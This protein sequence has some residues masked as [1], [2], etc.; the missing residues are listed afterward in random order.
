[1]ASEGKNLVGVDIGSN[2]IKVAEIKE[3]RKG[4]RTLVRFG[5][6][7]LPPQTIVDGHVMNSGAVVE[8]LQK[9]FHKA[10]RKDIAMR[11]S[12]HSVI[13]KKIT[14]PLMNAT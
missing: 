11:A 10:R 4:K 9:L 1:M 13:I 3:G 2:S 5:F 7:P 12:G 14:M 6:H 8:G